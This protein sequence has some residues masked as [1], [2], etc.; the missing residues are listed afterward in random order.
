MGVRERLQ[1][2]RA[3][4][5]RPGRAAVP[6]ARRRHRVARR[7]G[8]Q[9]RRDPLRAAS[10]SGAVA[11]RAVRAVRRRG[12][13]GHRDRRHL[14]PDLH[15][16]GPQERPALPGHLDGPVHLDQARPDLPRLQHLLA[17]YRGSCDAVEQGRWH[18]PGAGER[19]VPHVLRRGLDLLR[20]VRR[21]DP[22][23]AVPQR[24]A[25]HAADPEGHVRGVPRRGGSPADPH[26]QR[27]DPADAQRGG[28]ER[29]RVG[30]T[31]SS[32]GEAG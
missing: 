4:Q 16:V 7:P 27:P 24:P 1:P 9:R 23:D 19:Q 15:R 6:R 21:P 10:R 13:P 12:S 31:Y 5:G 32:V 3:G 11:V 18:P 25:G 30:D 29:R 14:L 20:L 8:D 26:Q 2:G 17:S 22:L 28:E